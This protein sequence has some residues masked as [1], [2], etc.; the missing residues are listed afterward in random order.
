MLTYVWYFYFKDKAF[1][2]GSKATGVSGKS[3]IGWGEQSDLV[4]LLD[5]LSA[6]FNHCLLVYDQC[7]S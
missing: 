6:I 7:A 4:V 1:L 2:R 3:Y 5:Q